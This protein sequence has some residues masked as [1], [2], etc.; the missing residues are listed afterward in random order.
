MKNASCSFTSI[1]WVNSLRNHEHKIQVKVQNIYQF[2]DGTNGFCAERGHLHPCGTGGSAD[3]KCLLGALLP[4]APHRSRWRVCGRCRPTELSWGPLQHL[5]SYWELR[6]PRSQSNIRRP[7]ALGDRWAVLLY[8]ELKP[9]GFFL[10]NVGYEGVAA[11]GDGG[12]QATSW[13]GQFYL[14]FN[15]G[16]HLQRSVRLIANGFIYQ[17]KSLFPNLSL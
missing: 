4:G 17:E 15:T 11:D 5:L 2:S 10:S 12:I 7:G 3:R 6:A 16:Y 13:Q 8:V 9:P 14:L 1:Y